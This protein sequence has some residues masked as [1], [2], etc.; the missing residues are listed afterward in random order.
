M[1]TGGWRYRSEPDELAIEAADE[2]DRLT[3]LVAEGEEALT[4]QR[5]IGEGV[6]RNGAPV[7]D[8]QGGCVYCGVD[9]DYNAVYPHADDCAWKMAVMLDPDK[10]RAIHREAYVPRTKLRLVPPQKSARG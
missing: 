8:E 2:I 1:V 7:Q 10:A 4:K 6:L 3:R 5:A 9:C